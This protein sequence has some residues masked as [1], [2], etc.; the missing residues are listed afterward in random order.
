MVNRGRSGRTLALPGKGRGGR[1]AGR[2]LKGCLLSRSDPYA[3]E[4]VA[5]PHRHSFVGAAT[6]CTCGYVVMDSPTRTSMSRAK[7]RGESPAPSSSGHRPTRWYPLRPRTTTSRCSVRLACPEIAYTHGATVSSVEEGTCGT[8]IRWGR[9]SLARDQHG[10]RRGPNAREGSAGV[11]STHS[12]LLSGGGLRNNAVECCRK[13]RPPE[14]RPHARRVSNPV[15]THHDLER[16]QR[17]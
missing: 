6:D 1:H 12:R 13:R 8:E 5:V 15:L 4:A 17:L 14:Y 7:R 11:T 9:L 2:A 16:P 10:A 3:R